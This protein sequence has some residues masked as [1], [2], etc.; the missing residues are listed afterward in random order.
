M[1]Q[2]G[3]ATFI[4]GDV[5]DGAGLPGSGDGVTLGAHWLA[6]LL[7]QGACIL[8]AVGNGDPTDEPI[9]QHH[10][11]WWDAVNRLPKNVRL[12]LLASVE[13]TYGKLPDQPNGDAS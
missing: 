2:S 6:N 5:R 7:Y 13:A 3:S 9:V 11:A 4:V 8:V 12:W 1:T 10:Q